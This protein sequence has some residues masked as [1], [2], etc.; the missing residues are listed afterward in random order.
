MDNVFEKV[1]SVGLG[2]VAAVVTWVVKTLLTNK[3]QVEVVKTSM[4][5]QT[6]NIAELKKTVEALR[7][8][9]KDDLK[10]LKDDLVLIYKINNK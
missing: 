6:E 7:K 3:E 1:L 5:N 2:L 9:F 10:D 8:E 4:S